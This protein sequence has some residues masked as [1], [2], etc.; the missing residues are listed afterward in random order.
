MALLVILLGAYALGVLL[1][2]YLL[3]IIFRWAVRDILDI[4]PAKKES[5]G[6]GFWSWWSC[7]FML[8]LGSVIYLVATHGR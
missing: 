2:C 8:I 5:S 7:L 3:Y 1:A 6:Q 4:H